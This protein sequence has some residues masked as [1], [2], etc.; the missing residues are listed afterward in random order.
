MQI[1]SPEHLT[2][3]KNLLQT[4][5]FLVLESAI[6][7][8]SKQGKLLASVLSLEP[9]SRFVKDRRFRNGRRPSNRPPHS[10]VSPH[11]FRKS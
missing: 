4:E 6:G 8:L 9:L 10:A 5:L 1:T 2:Q 3:F 11:L 7:P